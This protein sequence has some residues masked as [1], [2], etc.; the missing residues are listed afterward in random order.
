MQPREWRHDEVMKERD[1]EIL[2]ETLIRMLGKS[3]K[4]VTDLTDRVNQLEMILR[5][6][7]LTVHYPIGQ[8]D[9]KATFAKYP[10]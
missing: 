3:N 9:E 10:S 7:I 6:S 5:E 1:L 2:V 8:S 4:K